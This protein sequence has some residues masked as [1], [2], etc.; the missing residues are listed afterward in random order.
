MKIIGI[1]GGTG[2]G[3]TFLTNK[4]LE[5]FGEKI[6]VI[7]LDSYYKDLRHI[8]F[9]LREK[10]N[11]DH[12]DSFDFD[13]LIKDLKKLTQLNQV[14]IPKY[15]YK[16]HTRKNQTSLVYKKELIIIEGIFSLYD[17]TIRDK[18]FYKIFLDSDEKNRFER[19]LKRDVK[20]R[21]RTKESILEQF[22]N[23]VKP[24]HKKFVNPTKKYADIIIKNNESN[25]NSFNILF[26]KIRKLL[27]LK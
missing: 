11:F 20:Y 22:N 24:M 26:N 21:K 9:N 5:E 1:A 18:M 7:K 2:S 6:D 17:K 15:N 25:S 16:N 10:Y 8:D 3:K 12:P 23:T 13:L 14:E 27:I 19:R 4:L